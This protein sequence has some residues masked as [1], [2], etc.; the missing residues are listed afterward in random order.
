VFDRERQGRRKRKEREDERR[1]GKVDVRSV[2]TLSANEEAVLE[3][4]V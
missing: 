1:K 3:P 4:L 2:E